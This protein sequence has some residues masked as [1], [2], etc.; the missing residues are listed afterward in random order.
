MRNSVPRVAAIHDLSGF[1]RASLTVVIPILSSMGIQVCPLPTAVLSSHSAYKD[2]HAIDLTDELQ[3][4]IDHWKR[5]SLDFDAIYSGYLGS[6]GQVDTVKQFI[7]DFSGNQPL[8]VVDPVLGDN[9][10]LYSAYTPAMVDKMK[11]LVTLADVITPN[12]TEAAFLLGEVHQP[13]IELSE[14]KQWARRLAEMGPNKVIIT[15]VP[16]QMKNNNTSVVA[17]NQTDNRFWRVS[18]DYIPAHYPGTGDAFASVMVGSLLQG[19][20]LP[21]ALDRAVQFIALGVRATFGHNGRATE[22]I[23]LEK[24]L[25]SLNAPVQMS[26]YQLLD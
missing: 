3:P 8:V 18:C 15:S 10:A 25:P 6:A 17:F 14:I 22:G 5:L 1:G 19:D 13:E 26:S 23:L 9:G 4:M 7:H 20:S 21:I 2:L 12:L 11:E 24:V 16:D